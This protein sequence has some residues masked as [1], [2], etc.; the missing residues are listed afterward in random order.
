MDHHRA[1]EFVFTAIAAV[2][3]CRRLTEAIAADQH[4]VVL[5]KKGK[6]HGRSN[7][8][9]TE[10][11]YQDV[12]ELAETFAESV[13]HWHFDGN[14][15]RMEFLVNR[16]GERKSS[17]DPRT[18]RQVPACRLVLTAAGTIELLNQCQRITAALQ[19]AGL[20]KTAGGPEAARRSE[21]NARELRHTQ[22]IPAFLRWV[23][24]FAIC[25]APAYPAFQGLR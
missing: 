24:T 19:K 7:H 18:V 9:Q 12:P 10:I 22:N 4:P 1:K 23:A 13:G 16:M 5:E 2:K 17:S 8:G 21:L 6:R 20:V 15:L 11:Q 3:V 25:A 14:T